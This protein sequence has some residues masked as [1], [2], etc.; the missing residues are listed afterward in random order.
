MDKYLINLQGQ[1][2][3]YLCL[4]DKEVMDWVF[5]SSEEI[6]DFMKDEFIKFQMGYGI[7]EEKVKEELLDIQ[8]HD[9]FRDDNDKALFVTS[10]YE[11]F[12][13]V[14]E[15]V[16]FCKEND[17]NIVEEYQGYIY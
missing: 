14:Q 4:V 10:A 12:Y 3:T 15:L 9:S 2:D 13:T 1:G 16:D 6:P 7:S 8:E 17:I 11:S 5:S